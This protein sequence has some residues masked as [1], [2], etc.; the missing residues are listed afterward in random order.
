MET[1][2]KIRMKSYKVLQSVQYRRTVR[3][4]ETLR[5]SKIPVYVSDT[6]ICVVEDVV[7]FVL[8]CPKCQQEYGSWGT[9]YI[10][11]LA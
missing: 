10:S 5:E 3:A 8:L 1:W 11:G 2:R 4:L 6:S 9:A 7:Y